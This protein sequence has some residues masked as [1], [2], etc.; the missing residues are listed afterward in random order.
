[1]K[2]YTRTGDKGQTSLFDGSR[3]PKSD[4]RVEAYGTIDELNSI[5]GFGVIEVA[6]M[7]MYHNAHIKKMKEEMVQIQC[8]LFAIGATLATPAAL[9]VGGLGK[10]TKMLEKLIDEMTA[11]MP[12]LKNFVLPGGGKAGALMHICRT[13][14]RRAERRVVDL[15]QTEGVDEEIVKYLNRL[16]DLLFT[17]ARYIN[18]IEK[19]DEYIW[20]K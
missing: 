3:V 12:E 14:C 17:Q 1:M 8:D 11:Q 13:V 10:R 20:K 18:F 4:S 2:I 9:P 6:S 19:K 16:S 5:L 7:T 15:M